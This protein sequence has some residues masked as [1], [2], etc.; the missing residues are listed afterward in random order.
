MHHPKTKKGKTM[1]MR[2]LGINEVGENQDL[3]KLVQM[4]FRTP[5]SSIIVSNTFRHSPMN[6]KTNKQDR[7]YIVIK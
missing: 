5:A 1:I 2:C 4:R 7:P 6:V 3:R